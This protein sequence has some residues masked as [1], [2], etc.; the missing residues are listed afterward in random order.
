MDSGLGTA[1]EP[2]GIF[3]VR[4][5]RLVFPANSIVI[6]A[7]PDGIST[8]VK[9]I[10]LSRE[11]CPVWFDVALEQLAEADRAHSDVLA[12]CD[13]S[14]N[15]RLGE[16]LETEAAHGMQAIVAA[17]TALDALYASAK[18]C[19]KLPP[20]Q[21]ETWRKNGTARWRQVAEVLRRCFRV[22]RGEHAASV[23]LVVREVYRF[24]DMAVHP[25]S[26][27]AQVVLHPDLNK[28]TDWRYVSFSF[29]SAQQAVWGSLNLVMQLLSLPDDRDSD[30]LKALRVN[31][32][33]MLAPVTARWE[34][35]YGPL[36]DK[37]GESESA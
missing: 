33:T 28:G 22:S 20:S 11:M 12:T 8:S 18:E 7:D 36:K 9:E 31:L 17:A 13:G 10:R 26:A 5:S 14:D 1:G 4:H 19:I 23:R 35:L 21:V 29:A 2:E 24:R 25:S 6:T 3:L 34:D 15:A 16:S 27:A 37:P 32:R 30:E